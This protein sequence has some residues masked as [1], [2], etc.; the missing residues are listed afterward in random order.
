MTL[1]SLLR[2]VLIAIGT[3]IK[4]IRAR[5]AAVEGGAGMDPSMAIVNAATRLIQTQRITAQ[6][7]LRSTL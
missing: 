3:D 6:I 5:L 7:V 1:A 2:D 4:G